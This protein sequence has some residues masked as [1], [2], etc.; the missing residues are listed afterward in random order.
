MGH[1]ARCPAAW[2]AAKPNAGVVLR[3]THC[4]MD[5][6]CLCTDTCLRRMSGTVR[7]SLKGTSSLRD[8]FSMVGTCEVMGELR[9]GAFRSF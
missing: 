5:A 4:W 9:T 6:S 2:E 1:A 8:V 3:C 7:L